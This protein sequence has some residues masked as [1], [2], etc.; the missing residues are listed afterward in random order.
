M[1]LS[2]ERSGHRFGEPRYFEDLV[3]GE[4][5]YIPSRTMTEAHFAA[6]QTISADNHPIHYDREYCRE[7]GH[8]GPLAHG[9]QILLFSAAGASTFAHQISDA[10]IAFVEQSSKFLKPVCAGDTLYPMLEIAALAPQRS[11][12]VV[13]LNA[14]IHNQ[15]SELVLTG[16]QKILLRKRPI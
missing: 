4:R 11:T 5:F 16:E 14:T 15:N 9:F 13:T 6:F 8:K 1:S 10:L 2:F 12:G 3:L 7:R